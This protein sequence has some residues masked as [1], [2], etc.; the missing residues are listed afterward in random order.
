METCFFSQRLAVHATS[1]RPCIVGAIEYIDPATVRGRFTR[2]TLDEVQICLPAQ[3][4][5]QG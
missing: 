2:H 5:H 4:K 1:D 3:D